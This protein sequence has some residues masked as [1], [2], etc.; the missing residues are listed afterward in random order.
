MAGTTSEAEIDIEKLGIFLHP[1]AMSIYHRLASE[2]DISFTALAEE[3]GDRAVTGFYLAQLQQRNF[4]EARLELTGQSDAR[5]TYQMFFSL[6]ESVLR[7]HL[8]AADIM[9]HE[10]RM[11]LDTSK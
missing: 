4:V 11:L 9:L 6:N 5:Y 8:D 1:Y 2:D 7:N 3:A 10:Y